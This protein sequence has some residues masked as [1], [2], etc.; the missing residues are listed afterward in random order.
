MKTL[1]MYDAEL[2]ALNALIAKSQAIIDARDVDAAIT[3]CYSR[4]D[5]C[6]RVGTMERPVKHI[7]TRR[8]NAHL[9]TACNFSIACFYQVESRPLAFGLPI[10]H[11][12][13][14]E[15]L[16]SYVLTSA[17]ILPGDSRWS[18]GGVR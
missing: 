2:A 6:N 1:E 7:E 18:K 8:V 5:E 9:C 4:C 12:D 10:S 13:G 14:W 16:G 3:E 17:A 11:T 15:H